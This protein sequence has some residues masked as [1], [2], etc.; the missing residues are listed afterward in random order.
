MRHEPPLKETAMCKGAVKDNIR[1][2]L[3][4]KNKKQ[5]PDYEWRPRGGTRF[6][7]GNPEHAGSAG[8]KGEKGAWRA[9]G[10]VD[11]A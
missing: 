1:S 3:V 5:K 8:R 6:T 11:L 2:F 7:A 4:A 9:V 10:D